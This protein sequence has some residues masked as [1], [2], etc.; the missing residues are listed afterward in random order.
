MVARNLEPIYDNETAIRAFALV[1]S[2]YPDATLTIAGSGPEAGTLQAL[3]DHLALTTAVTFTGRLEPQAIANLY[4][5]ADIAINPSLVDNMPNSVLEALASGIPVVSTNV[6]GVPYIV[7]DGETALLVPARSPEAMASAITRL[8]EEP[9]LCSQLIDNGMAEV[10][11]YTWD[12]VWPLWEKVYQ[13]ALSK[14]TKLV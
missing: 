5:E 3:T 4:R 7:S 14:K 6:G 1:R 11:R 12:T 9:S 8:I 10:Q 2:R 13:S